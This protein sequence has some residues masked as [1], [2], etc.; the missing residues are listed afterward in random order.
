M[1]TFKY[2]RFQNVCMTYIN[3][4]DAITKQKNNV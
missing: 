3:H 4:L 2:A 1:K